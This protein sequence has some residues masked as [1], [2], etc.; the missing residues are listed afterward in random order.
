MSDGDREAKNDVR[1]LDAQTDESMSTGQLFSERFYRVIL[2]F[3]WLHS[4]PPTRRK[5]RFQKRCWGGTRKPIYRLR[6]KQYLRHV[7]RKSRQASD[8][9]L[10][11]TSVSRSVPINRR[12]NI[13]VLIHSRIFSRRIESFFYD[14]QQYFTGL[15]D[16]LNRT[17]FVIRRRPLY[18][19][20]LRIS[21]FRVK[22]KPVCVVHTKKKQYFNISAASGFQEIEY[23]T[24]SAT[25]RACGFSCGRERARGQQRRRR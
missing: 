1:V 17:R 2:V 22:P 18:M 10:I 9:M 8:S 4:V 24:P 19:F 21:D 6:N 14:K 23:K 5:G 20:M 25:V 11:S 3:V 13:T 15:F 7:T 16:L 12:A